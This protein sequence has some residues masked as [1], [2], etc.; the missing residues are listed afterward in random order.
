MAHA[1]VGYPEVSGAGGMICWPFRGAW[2]MMDIPTL[3]TNRLVLRGF[4][5]TDLDAYAAM[6]ADPAVRR[7]L[8][9]SLLSR[10]QA[11][12]QMESLLGQ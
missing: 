7:W 10:E 5:A 11:W 9:G 1:G 4:T 2:R 6:N 8:G 3:T 12:A